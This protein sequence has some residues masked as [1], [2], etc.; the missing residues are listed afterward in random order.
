MSAR[1]VHLEP[2][3]PHSFEARHEGADPFVI[4]QTT[5]GWKT[6]GHPGFD[7]LLRGSLEELV[8]EIEGVS[9]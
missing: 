7:G 1:T 8:A 3:G 6:E 5:D 4:R 9:N 2:M